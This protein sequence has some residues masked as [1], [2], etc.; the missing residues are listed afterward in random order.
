M[1]FVANLRAETIDAFAAEKIQPAAYLLSSH[2]IT[3]ATL[4]EAE[5]VRELG[6]PLF[7]DNGTKPLIDLTLAD[8]KDAARAIATEV[9]DIRHALGR[10]PRGQDIPKAL[11]RAAGDLADAVV[12]ATV[13]RSKAVDTDA[14]IDLQMSMAPTDLIAQEDFATACLMGLGLEREITGWPVSRF[15][16]RNRRSLR[17]WARVVSDP[18]CA[19]IRVFAVLSATDYN[20]AI[21]AGRLAAEAGVTHAALGFAGINLDRS[22]VDSYVLGHA[23]IGL[24]RPVPRR[25]VRLAQIVCGLAEGFRQAGGTLAAFHCLGLGAPVMFPIVAAGFDSGTTVTMDA[26]SPIHDA[27]RDR[28]LYDAS[29]DGDRA[30]ILEIVRRIVAGGDWPF[31]GP[32]TVSFRRKFGH[33]PKAARAW[34]AENGHDTIER[35]HLS[36]PSALTRA[37]PLFTAA[38]PDIF[39]AARKTWI[40]HNHW[41]LD[42]VGGQLSGAGRRAA[43]LASLARQIDDAPSLTVT[44]KGLAAAREALERAA[45]PEQE[46]G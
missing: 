2:R 29:A 6:L 26:T 8:F 10:S 33:D 39:A 1:L 16:T 15:E 17:L 42:L 13:A 38:D 31:L 22:A 23:S 41:V 19:G 20:T 12:D 9:R 18:R 37:L 11:R 28:V 44:V 46:R 45:I 25:Y 40:A 4:A 21:A 27:V 30:S 14:L 7:A 35:E 43:A 5:R 34:A 3:P 36:T 24:E 32:F